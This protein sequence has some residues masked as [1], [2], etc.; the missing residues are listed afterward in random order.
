VNHRPRRR[1]ACSGQ[2]QKA[3]PINLAQRSSR[4]P[5]SYVSCLLRVR[6]D[7]PKVREERVRD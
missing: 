2:F 4:E 3:A 7:L 1:Q 5:P 6:H